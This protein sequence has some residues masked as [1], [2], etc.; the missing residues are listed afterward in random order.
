MLTYLF[1]RYFLDHSL[2]TIFKLHEKTSLTVST[3]MVFIF[4]TF[5]LDF[6]SLLKRE[7]QLRFLTMVV[8]NQVPKPWNVHLSE[9]V[10]MSEY[11]SKW[12]LFHHLFANSYCDIAKVKIFTKFRNSGYQFDAR[13]SKSERLAFQSCFSIPLYFFISCFLSCLF[14]LFAISQSELPEIYMPYHLCYKANSSNKVALYLVPL[15][16]RSQFSLL[17]FTSQ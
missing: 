13:A 12:L 8:F 16:L 5:Q 15:N 4:I 9:C 1:I 6:Q 3:L 10:L 2:N 7:H 14:V 17:L 11:Q